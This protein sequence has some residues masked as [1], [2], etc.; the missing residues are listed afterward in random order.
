[1]IGAGWL[2]GDAAAARLLPAPRGAG[3]PAV[4]VA[5]VLGFLAVLSVAL[6]LAAGRLAA[7]WRGPEAGTATLQIYE[8]G[9]D[10]E[11]QARAALD[12]LRGTPGV[13]RV[14]VIEIDEQRELI[15]PWLGAEVAADALPLPLLIE[16][17]TDA[18]VLDSGALTARMAD[19]VPGAVY[20][21]HGPMRAELVGSALG[22]RR[23]ALACLGLMAV[24]LG[25]VFA[26]GARVAV[27]DNA[28]SIR[29]LRL[30]GA[31]DGYIAGVLTRRA[32]WRALAGAAMGALAGMALVALLPSASE[33]GF[34]LVGIGPRDG[35]WA[36]GL[37][38]PPA[39]ALI[40]WLAAA[41]TVRRQLRRWS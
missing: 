18:G 5:A 13:E 7:D 16:V 40:G 31:R 28:Q 23:F 39:A 34:F 12:V 22:L 17:K 2:R 11:A 1:V 14:R 27:A 25:A 6:A 10:I 15:E 37:L 41:R 38:V 24:A 19:A 32:T 30:V 35:S 26:L 4:L 36:L 20:D 29:T 9:G 3:L 21:D 33:P 8:D